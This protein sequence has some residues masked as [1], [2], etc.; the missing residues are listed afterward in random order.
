MKFGLFGGATAES[1]PSQSATE[2][3][4]A[5]WQENSGL[6]PAYKVLRI[7]ASIPGLREAFTSNVFAVFRRA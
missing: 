4:T 1:S 6:H 5:K 2:D 3:S 7:F